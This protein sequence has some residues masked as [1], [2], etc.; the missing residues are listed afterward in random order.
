MTV[1]TVLPRSGR[2]LQDDFCSLKSNAAVIFRGISAA[3]GCK[4][5]EAGQINNH[6]FL[7]L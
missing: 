2:K 6:F 5:G 1:P 3:D 7:L 4:G